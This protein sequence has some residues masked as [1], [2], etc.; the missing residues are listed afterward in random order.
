M[1]W[2]NA[3]TTTPARLKLLFP[4][5]RKSLS[6][7]GF[8]DLHV[9]ID[10]VP[11]YGDLREIREHYGIH[12]RTTINPNVGAIGN[13]LLTLWWLW[14]T[15]PDA[16]V[17]AIFQDDLLM[18]KGVRAYVEESLAILPEQAYLN[19]Y[20]ASANYHLLGTDAKPKKGYQGWYE[21]D[22]VGRGAL[23]LVFPRSAVPAI[24]LWREWI[25]VN[26]RTC[27]DGVVAN[28]LRYAHFREYVHSPS[29]VQ[30]VGV[31]SLLGHPFEQ[32]PCY[33]DSDVLQVR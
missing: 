9:H 18:S 4:L 31:E 8:T 13:W 27:I 26:T 6:A 14:L 3:I 24:L 11:S 10:G 15:I 28:A 12:E 17:Y 5:T 33:G 22:Q 21:S 2:A 30:H 25:G 16:D 32:S 1:R 20:T 23:A 29:L 7:A 19:L